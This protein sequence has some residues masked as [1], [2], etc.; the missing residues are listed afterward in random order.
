MVLLA[1]TIAVT[2]ILVISH[3]KRYG[4]LLIGTYAGE[5]LIV[6]IIKGVITSP[7]P[8]NALVEAAY[9]SFPSSHVSAS[10]VFFGLLT[11]IAW[12]K[13]QTP[14]IRA[15]VAALYVFLVALVGV[16]RIYLNVHWLTDVVGAVLL[17]AFWLTFC[18]ALFN[19]LTKQGN[20][21]IEK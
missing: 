13:W 15:P 16:D 7:R 19:R 6:N 21:K 1:I 14:K 10:V 20:K 2:I 12:K 8:T 9:F 5:Y 4:I 17:G 11:F 3:H 18:L